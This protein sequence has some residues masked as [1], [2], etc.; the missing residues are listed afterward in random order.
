ME[1]TEQI[2]PLATSANGGGMRALAS[3]VAR[4]IADHPERRYGPSVSHADP[5]RDPEQYLRD[6]TRSGLL[7]AR[8]YSDATNETQVEYHAGPGLGTLLD[9][10]RP[11]AQPA[12][13]PTFQGVAVSKLR[14]FGAAIN[15][16]SQSTLDALAMAMGKRA[17]EAA[18]LYREYDRSLA[19][20]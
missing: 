6:A 5:H 18:A 12:T 13:E 8:Y 19:P 17:H 7:K 10:A 20:K 9:R 4:A 15:S 16:R 2:Q 3:D 14:E 1:T 11:A